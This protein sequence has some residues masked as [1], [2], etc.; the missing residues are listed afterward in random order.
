MPK[1]RV[2][3][4]EFMH[5]LDH[6]LKA[7]IE[8]VRALIRT[9][10]GEVSEQIKWNAPSFGYN[11]E[12]RITFRLHPPTQFQLIFHRGAKV[13]EDGATFN[14]EDKRGLL[15]WVAPDRAMVTLRNMD[16]VQTHAAALTEL[17]KAW[18]HATRA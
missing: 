4:E 10:D 7:E 13:R 2:S 14:F 15:Q 16:E 18:L 17:V 11:G 9:A 3:V 1:K 6:P 8:A 12:D 5:T